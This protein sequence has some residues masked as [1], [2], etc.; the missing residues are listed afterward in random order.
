M[1]PLQLWAFLNLLLLLV[2]PGCSDAK[3]RTVAQRQPASSGESAG[4]IA[5]GARAYLEWTEKKAF[6]GNAD[7]VAH[8]MQKRSRLATLS[9]LK[10]DGKQTTIELD[11]G[12]GSKGIVEQREDGTTLT[13]ESRDG[14]KRIQELKQDKKA[15]DSKSSPGP[16]VPGN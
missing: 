6:E 5:D 13:I 11:Y 9:S 7:T 10:S 14:T 4:S 3:H 12:D 16:H 15:G 1:R 8:E 2:A